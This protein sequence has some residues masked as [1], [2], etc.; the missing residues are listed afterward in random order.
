[1]FLH[2]LTFILVTAFAVP[3]VALAQTAPTPPAITPV[4]PAS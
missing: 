4:K 3:S 1:M 2:K